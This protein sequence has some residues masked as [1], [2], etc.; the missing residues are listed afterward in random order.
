MFLL[1]FVYVFAD[2]FTNKDVFS[3]TKNDFKTE[4]ISDQSLLD[5]M[6][7]HPFVLY[8]GLLYSLTSLYG[9]R[10]TNQEFLPVLDFKTL[11]CFNYHFS[12]HVECT[13]LFN[14]L[15][16]MFV[17]HRNDITTHPVLNSVWH[18][19]YVKLW[20]QCYRFCEVAREQSDT[21]DRKYYCFENFQIALAAVASFAPFPRTNLGASGS[22]TNEE[23]V[24]GND[25]TKVNTYVTM[26]YLMF[27]TGTLCFY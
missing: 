5:D 24:V 14:I 9:N 13:L 17:P 4:D 3:V 15:Y 27:H 6:L 22:D 21:S 18:N 11:D 25:D 23:I 2:G 10:K 7:G 12:I 8:V 1:C 16:S 20:D 26:I 19:S